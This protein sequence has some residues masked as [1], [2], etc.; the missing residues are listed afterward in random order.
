MK[1]GIVKRIYLHGYQIRHILSS[2]NANY[3]AGLLLETKQR[4]FSEDLEVGKFLKEHYCYSISEEV[5]F[6]H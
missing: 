6:K 1:H 2:S 3:G 4:T 5:I